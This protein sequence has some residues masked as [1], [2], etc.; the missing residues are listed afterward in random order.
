VDSITYINHCVAECQGV[1]LQHESECTAAAAGTSLGLGLAW[2]A[3]VKFI[4]LSMTSA[5]GTAHLA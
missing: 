3:K 5:A 1:E 4:P 2:L